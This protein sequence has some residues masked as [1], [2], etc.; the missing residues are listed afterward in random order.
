MNYYIY[1]MRYGLPHP[2]IFLLAADPG[3]IPH[4]PAEYIVTMFRY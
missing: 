2:A 3:P 4:L 1:D